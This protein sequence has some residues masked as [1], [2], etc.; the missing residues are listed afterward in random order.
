M[1][2]K[3]NVKHPDRGTSNYPARLSARGLSRA[4][5]LAT[6]DSLRRR[7]ATPDWLA[8]HPAIADNLA[9]YHGR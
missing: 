5:A 1:A 9:A 8:A 4:P 2:R 3:H 7:Q 6:V